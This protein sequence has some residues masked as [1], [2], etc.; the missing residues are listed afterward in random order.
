[1]TAVASIHFRSQAELKEHQA[2]EYPNVRAEGSFSVTPDLFTQDQRPELEP[3]LAALPDPAGPSG[4]DFERVDRLAGALT[5]LASELPASRT[6]FENYMALVT[7]V[8]KKKRARARADAVLPA[9]LTRPFTGTATR[10]PSP[11]DVL[12]GAAWHVLIAHRPSEKWRPLEISGAIR[13]QVRGSKHAE[14]LDAAFNRIDS[15]LRN[16]LEFEPFTSG[17]GLDSARA[18]LLVLL[19][20]EPDRQLAWTPEETGADETVRAAA[21][22]LSG[23][24]TGRKRLPTTLRPAQLDT[25][26]AALELTL[27]DM[28]DGLVPA[29][30]VDL[31]VEERSSTSGRE[32]ALSAGGVVQITKR[33]R[34]VSLTDRLSNVELRPG[35]ADY[36]LALQIAEELGWVDAVTTVV[37]AGN[38]FAALRSDDA[39][40]LRVE[41]IPEITRV[42]NLE[43]FRRRLES[44]GVPDELSARVQDQ[45]SPNDVT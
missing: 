24:L 35:E 18:L 30:T 9:W 16:E 2:R 37:S 31:K 17:R 42:L 11:D 7:S 39:I 27:L 22:V 43:G 1:M 13:E 34:G 14:A 19:R 10:A 25:L 45:K 12:F 21:A 3:W 4:N 6:A 15:I 33:A 40:E 29:P 36:E 8:V 20:P 32:L 44:D 28:P 5:I 23:L 41:G 26:F 38:G